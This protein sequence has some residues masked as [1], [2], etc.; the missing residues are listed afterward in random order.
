MCKVNHKSGNYRTSS[1]WLVIREIV[2]TLVLCLYDFFHMIVSEHEALS[3]TPS[4]SKQK[5]RFTKY[6]GLG[7]FFAFLA[8]NCVHCIALTKRFPVN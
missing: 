8:R 7:S 5:L 6:V 3:C 2:K 4:V 1:I